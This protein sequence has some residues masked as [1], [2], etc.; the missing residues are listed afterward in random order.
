M[1]HVF[2]P[3]TKATPIRGVLLPGLNFITGCLIEKKEFNWNI[4]YTS[5]TVLS[6]DE[7]RAQTKDSSLPYRTEIKRDFIKESV[8]F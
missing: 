5:P 7:I 6:Y 8:T 4:V 3:K 1:F 2:G